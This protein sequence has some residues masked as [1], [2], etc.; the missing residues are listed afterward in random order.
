MALNFFDSDGVPIAYTKDEIN[1]FFYDGRPVGIIDHRVIFSYTGRYLGVFED[2][3]LIDRNGDHVLFT[4][5]SAGGP[6]TPLPQIPPIPAVPQIPPIRSM[7]EMPPIYP[8]RSLNWSS[9][10]PE[11]FFG[12]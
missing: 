9:L 11:Q 6:L 7:P 3:W 8:M 10:T 2:G 1:I 12:I 4:E 5:N